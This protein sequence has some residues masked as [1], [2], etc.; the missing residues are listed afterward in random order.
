M[1]MMELRRHLRLRVDLMLS[2]KDSHF[3]AASDCLSLLHRV[4]Q[5]SCYGSG[6]KLVIVTSAIRHVRVPC[7]RQIRPCCQLFDA[8]MVEQTGI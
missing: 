6:A 1:A 3:L 4:S 7:P 2:L 5:V 8:N